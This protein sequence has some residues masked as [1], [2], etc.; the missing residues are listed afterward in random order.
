MLRNDLE[1][2][3]ELI[4]HHMQDELIVATVTLEEEVMAIVES[5]EDEVI[6]PRA[7]D[8]LLRQKL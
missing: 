4:A 7:W 2:L 1:R 8:L 5:V 6:P 3:A